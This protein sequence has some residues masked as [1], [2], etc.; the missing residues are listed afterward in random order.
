MPVA[1]TT[2]MKVRDNA[3]DEGSNGISSSNSTADVP[4]VG[5]IQ[6][7]DKSTTGESSSSKAGR[8]WKRNKDEIMG[9][10]MTKVVESMT[11]SKQSSDRMFQN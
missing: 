10:I 1:I 6:S 11:D 9:E 3:G 2:I 4:I 5:Y 8:K 7:A